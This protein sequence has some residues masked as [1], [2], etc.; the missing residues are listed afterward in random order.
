MQKVEDDRYILKATDAPTAIID[1]KVFAVL[2]DVPPAEEWLITAVPQSGE[3]AYM[4]VKKT[5]NV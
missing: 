3:D 4:Y 5:L 1:D 2:L